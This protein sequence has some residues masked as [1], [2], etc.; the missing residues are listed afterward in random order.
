[1]APLVRFAGRT[2]AP[3]VWLRS[4]SVFALSSDTEQMPLSVLEAMA[5][6]RPVVSV[7]VGDVRGMVSEENR[8]FVVGPDVSS[9]AD[10]L[11]AMLDD[12]SRAERIGGANA[13]RAR[14]VF[15]QSKMFAAY[16]GLF[17]GTSP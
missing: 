2:A 1:M 10:A 16:G 3:E 8:M 6:G 14:E 13:R 17:D 9:M 15:C 4:F 12:P 5:A 7:D 11:V